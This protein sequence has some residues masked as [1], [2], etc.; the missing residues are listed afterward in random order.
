MRQDWNLP[1]FDCA[2]IRMHLV[3][4]RLQ[5]IAEKADL[6]FCP[7]VCSTAA[8]DVDFLLLRNANGDGN[9]IPATGCTGHPDFFRHVSFAPTFRS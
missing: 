3:R 1:K 4:E 8:T 7:P 5:A 9:E 6:F 2:W